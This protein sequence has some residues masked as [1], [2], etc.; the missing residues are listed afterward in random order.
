MIKEK[1]LELPYFQMAKNN[2]ASTILINCM[3][4]PR[5]NI[6]MLR[7]IGGKTRIIS[8]KDMLQVCGLMER[9]IWGNSCKIKVMGMEYTDGQ[10]ERY[11]MDKSSRL[12][13]KAM[14]NLDLL[15]AIT[16]MDSTKMIS[17]GVT[18]FL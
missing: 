14:E 2:M 1:D 17:V 4:A 8:V 6:K 5:L 12:K 7:V 10:M 11:I 9:N 15:R 3:A 18:E 13:E 16:I